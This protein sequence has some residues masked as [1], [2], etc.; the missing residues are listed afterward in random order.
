MRSQQRTAEKIEVPGMPAIAGLRL[1]R[2][3]GEADYSHIVAIV[4][5]CNKADGI[6]SV[7]TLEKVACTY[8]H[9]TNCDPQR[10]MLLV[11]VD[12]QPIAYSRVFWFQEASGKRVYF[13]FGYV[14]PEWRQQGVGQ[15]MLRHSE[16]RLRQIA[17]GHPDDGPRFLQT[18]ADSRQSGLLSLLQEEGYTVVRYGYEMRRPLNGDLPEAALPAGLEVRPAKPE[19]YRL[20]WD[21]FQEAFRDHW[22]YAPPQEEDYQ[23]WLAEPIFNPDLWQVAWDGDQVA[24]MVLNFVDEEENR[25]LN[26]KRGYTEGICVRRP[27]RRRGL[28]RALLVRSLY[29]HKAN[30]MTEAALGVDAENPNGA[31]QLYRSV[32]FQPVRQE[33][34]FEKPLNNEEDKNGTI[35]P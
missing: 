13:H 25:Q 17:A 29:M 12:G 30:G 28:A 10:D 9:L 5:A 22:G 27:W 19:H 26:R 21:A 3:R 18:Y 23:H 31:L 2:F 8:A 11:E 16:H 14:R 7:S 6:D 20:I 33:M 24:G 32:G 1:R 35:D 15:A 34:T 4:N